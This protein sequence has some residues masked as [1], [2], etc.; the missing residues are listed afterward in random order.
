MGGKLFEYFALDLRGRIKLGELEEEG[1]YQF[2]V[3]SD[4][5]SIFELEMDDNNRVELINNDRYTPT[6]MKCAAEPVYFGRNTKREF[7]M[8]YFQGPRMHIAL[9][10]LWRKVDL[11]AMG[12]ERFC[13]RAGNSL[14][15]DFNKVPSEPKAA[16]LELQERG[17]KVL[18]SQNF[19]LPT[20]LVENPCG[21]DQ[22]EPEVNCFSEQVVLDGRNWF[23]LNDD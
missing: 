17:W 9:M 4:D 23:Y 12:D 6:R 10:L 14:F 19:L 2:A 1:H 15:F 21:N 20:G 13:D 16:Y 3:I 11:E 22:Q 7:Q 8:K 18:D 5:G